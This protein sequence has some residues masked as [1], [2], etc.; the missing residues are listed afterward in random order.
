MG[1]TTPSGQK[2]G[3]YSYSKDHVW[4]A[5]LDILKGIPLEQADSQIGKIKTEWLSRDVVKRNLMIF[6]SAKELRTQFFIFLKEE[7]SEQTA[8]RIFSRQ[9]SLKYAGQ[10]SL[11]AQTV[12]SD[13]SQEAEFLKKLSNRLKELDEKKN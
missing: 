7:T 1:L 6:G 3:V 10:Q 2:V 9:E 12:L 13:G 4:S 8:V 11:K 5:C